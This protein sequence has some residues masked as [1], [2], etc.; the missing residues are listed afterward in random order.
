MASDYGAA[1]AAALQLLKFEMSIWGFTFSF[2][3]VMLF[4]MVAAIIIWFLV[5]V[6]IK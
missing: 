1:I 5:E 6:L 2:W 3:Q 4:G